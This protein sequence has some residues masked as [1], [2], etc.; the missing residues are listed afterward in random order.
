MLLEIDLAILTFDVFYA[1]SVVAREALSMSPLSNPELR[2][3][4]DALI[5]QSTALLQCP[6]RDWT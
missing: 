3:L 6:D 1:G 5:E 4:I 2:A